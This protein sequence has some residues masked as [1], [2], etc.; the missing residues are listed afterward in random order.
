MKK[1]TWSDYLSLALLAFMGLGLEMLYAF[2][3]EPMLFGAP[4]VEWTAAQNIL[5]WVLTCITWLAI[6][7][8]LVR[9]A[10][11]RYGFDLFA[12]KDKAKPGQWV[13]VAACG[14]V[15][16]VISYI[17]WQGFKV[18]REY[19][20][21]GWLKFLF[22]YIYYI[23]ETVIFC[24]I[25][26]FGQ[27]AGEVRFPNRRFPYGGVVAALTWGLVHILTRGSL[28]AGLVTALYGFVYGLIYFLLNKDIR[29]AF[30]IILFL[31]VM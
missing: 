19:T 11:K 16:L 1:A 27:Q 29:K 26:V 6:T 3:L 23:C 2:V 8:L 25:I 13:A 18:V 24:M 17:D 22:Q 20:F 28:E 5:H 21:N 7:V 30:P 10:K 12:F 4:M 15:M 9:F 31:F 14:I